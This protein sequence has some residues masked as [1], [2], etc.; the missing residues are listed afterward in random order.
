MSPQEYRRF[1]AIIIGMVGAS[2]GSYLLCVG[3]RMALRKKVVRAYSICP[4]CGH[5][6]SGFDLIPVFSW[7]FLKGRCRYCKAPIP[8]KHLMTELIMAAVSTLLFLKFGLSLVFLEG[9]VFSTFLFTASISDWISG[10]ADD[11][12]F[13]LP[14][15]IWAVF[16]PLSDNMTAELTRLAIAIMTYTGLLLIVILIERIMKRTVLGG[17]DIKALF[18][19]CLYLHWYGFINMLVL[20]I[21]ISAVLFFLM[22][23]LTK[24]ADISKRLMFPYIPVI[25]ISAVTSYLI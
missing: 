11:I 1:T 10:R 19:S 8:V 23:L 17:A 3:E 6:L 14:V 5:N 13:V 21:I 9:I 15:V 12:L 4:T 2:F 22:L 25:F 24:K 7:I 16:L 18:I 20:S